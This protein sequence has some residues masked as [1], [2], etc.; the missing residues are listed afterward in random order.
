MRWFP[1]P[2][3]HL[4][5]MLP[6]YNQTP[7]RVQSLSFCR[8]PHSSL[9]AISFAPSLNASILHV[10]HICVLIELLTLSSS[11]TQPS[12]Y[13]TVYCLLNSSTSVLT[14]SFP[15]SLVF[16]AASHSLPPC[17][18]GFNLF[19]LFLSAPN[20]PS[21]QSLFH[22]WSLSSSPHRLICLQLSLFPLPYIP[23]SL[24]ASLSIDPAIVFCLPCAGWLALIN[25]DNCLLSLDAKHAVVFLNE[26]RSFPYITRMPPLP[27]LNAGI[28][29]LMTEDNLLSLLIFF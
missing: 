20:T 10:Q 4:R 7:L 15:T 18:S 5:M 1:V 11:N 6:A 28:P 13:L 3:E 24:P 2:G 29:S 19:S 21:L 23:L 22:L 14:L 8:R 27:S 26:S 9:V 17:S 25:I 16:F 12:F